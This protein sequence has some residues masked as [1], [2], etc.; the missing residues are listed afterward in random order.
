M[1]INAG[2]SKHGRHSSEIKEVVR[3]NNRANV[4]SGNGRAFG[5]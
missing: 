5:L 3:R 4:R 1:P 2:L